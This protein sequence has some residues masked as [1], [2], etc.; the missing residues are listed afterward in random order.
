[1]S[2]V[3]SVQQSKSKKANYP[4]QKQFLPSFITFVAEAMKQRTQITA[5]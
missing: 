2:A 5:N 3:I 4:A 1:L